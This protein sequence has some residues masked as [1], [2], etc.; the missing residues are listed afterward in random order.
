MA[1]LLDGQPLFPGDSELDQLF[2]IQKT[3]GPLT[4][5]QLDAFQRNSRHVI[6][7]IAV[8]PCTTTLL[9]CDVFSGSLV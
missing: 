7:G 2:V 9:N 4:P 6:H 8:C 3:L 1:E 5:S